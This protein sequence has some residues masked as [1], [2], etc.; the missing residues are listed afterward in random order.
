MTH[1]GDFRDSS[2][3]RRPCRHA[4]FAELALAFTAVRFV[5]CSP[6][7]TRVL[8]SPALEAM[9]SSQLSR[10][11][12][13]EFRR[14]ARICGDAALYCDPNDP[15]ADIAKNIRLVA[16][17]PPLRERGSAKQY[18]LARVK[19]FSW[20]KCARQTFAILSRGNCAKSKLTRA[21]ATAKVRC[22]VPRR[23]RQVDRGGGCRRDFSA[24]GFHDFVLTCRIN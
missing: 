3:F 9:P 24:I 21:L 8:A 12:V 15:E 4:I 17:N 20:D 22:Q 7:S 5:C 16:D 11:G 14:C 23:L 10:C 1:D 19:E 2:K 13:R 6:R 18:G